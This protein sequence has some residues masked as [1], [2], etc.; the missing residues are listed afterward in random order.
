MAV[1]STP[2]REKIIIQPE[3]EQGRFHWK[4]IILAEE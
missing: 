3:V 4:E 2:Y 1:Y